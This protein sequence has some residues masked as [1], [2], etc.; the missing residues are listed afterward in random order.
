MGLRFTFSTSF[1]SLY[2]N[3]ERSDSCEAVNK[4]AEYVHHGDPKSFLTLRQSPER[5]MKIK[6][7]ILI[8]NYSKILNHIFK[9]V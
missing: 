5:N 1:S 8:I 3:V 2:P 9:H 6:M 4:R 7:M